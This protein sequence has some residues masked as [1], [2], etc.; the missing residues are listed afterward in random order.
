MHGNK[1]GRTGIDDKFMGRG[2]VNIGAWI[3]GRNMF[4]PIRGP[5]PDHTWE[6]WWETV[7]PFQTP[8]FV[9]THHAESEDAGLKPPRMYRQGQSMEADES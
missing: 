2:T 9:L 4:W 3:M 5:R 6:G 8:V 1:G 7:P